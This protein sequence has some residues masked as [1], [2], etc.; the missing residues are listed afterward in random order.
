VS[1][2]LRVH[3]T[4]FDGG[5]VVTVA[6]ATTTVDPSIYIRALRRRWL[7][8][9]VACL[10]GAVLAVM[11]S[12]ATRS[13]PVAVDRYYEATHKLIIDPE[14]THAR[15]APNLLQTALF[16]TGGDVPARVAEALGLDREAVSERVR[17]VTD[18]S[19]G[20]IEIATVASDTEEAASMADAF[21]AGLVDHLDAR[22]RVSYRAALATA[23]ADVDR[24]TRRIRMLDTEIAGLVERIQ[25]VE[26]AALGELSSLD[27]TGSGASG[28]VTDLDR[29]RALAQL[30][31]ELGLAETE[32]SA[33]W[34]LYAEAVAV[35]DDLEQVGPPKAMFITQD[36]IEPLEISAG[37]FGLRLAEGR[38]GFNNFAV[39]EV[40]PPVGFVGSAGPA[41]A[42]PVRTVM[43]AITAALLAAALVVVQT[44][45][46]RRIRTA[47]EIER[48]FGT[49]VLAEIPVSRPRPRGHRTPA[50]HAAEDT[51]SVI[52]ESYRRARSAI[53]HQ[54]G[55]DLVEGPIG[56]GDARVI[57]V[58]SPG[59]GDG[60]T[61]AAANLAT[62]FAESGLAVLVVDCDHR[63]PDLHALFGRRY[64]PRRAIDSGVRGLTL[65][66]D[67]AEPA[68]TNPS[69][70]VEAQRDL[71][72]RARSRY[73][74]IVVDAAPLLATDDATALLPIADQVV[75]VI[76]SGWTQ[77]AAAA[78]SADLLYRRGAPVAGVV[79]TASTDAGREPRVRRRSASSVTAPVG[80]PRP[81]GAARLREG[82]RSTGSA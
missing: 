71:I 28:V 22:G 1:L 50:L 7:L 12:V 79:V 4:V 65:V 41:T 26:E 56:D 69:T 66:A 33:R 81:R 21:A 64:E 70:V 27:V 5:G 48:C 77:R 24:R 57:M 55:A 46:D 9:L 43:G 63:S 76:R 47:G 75:M 18:E 15:E 68:T 3:P 23:E 10:V 20:V 29:E 59:H 60:R 58:T 19:V 67:A 30:R 36:V 78:A 40:P 62:L 17:T 73:D 38:R 52:T 45:F 39:G 13:G 2:P 82:R 53:L 32:R 25:V 54:F 74:V 42:L 14:L 31:N 49:S 44:R 6:A 11:T 72:A 80:M 37:E 34:Q 35:L 51:R 8:L 16:V 61:I